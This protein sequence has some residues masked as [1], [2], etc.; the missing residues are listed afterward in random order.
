[1]IHK[2]TE[3]DV[4]LNLAEQTPLCASKSQRTACLKQQGVGGKLL[5]CVYGAVSV[6]TA[7]N[8][9]LLTRF[10]RLTIFQT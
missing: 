4:T 10:Y 2:E 7:E 6:S 1:M 9:M 5:G 3:R 8:M